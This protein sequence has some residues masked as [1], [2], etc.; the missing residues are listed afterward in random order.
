MIDISPEKIFVLL[1]VAMLVLGPSRLG[2]VARGLGKARAHL[3]Q[4]SSSLPPEAVKVIR[5][6]RSLLDDALEEPRQMIDKLGEP[7]P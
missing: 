3:R 1:V 4:L 5:D 7:D 6:P 2:E